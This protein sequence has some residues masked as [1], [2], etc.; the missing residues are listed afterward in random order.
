MNQQAAIAIA[1]RP[2]NRI[3]TGLPDNE[4][5]RLAPYLE[6][7]RLETR[8]LVIDINQPIS[9]V[10]FLNTGV[11][12]LVGLMA[13][14]SPVETATIG[15][16]GM[17]GLPVFH[18]TDRIAAQAFCQ[19]PAEGLR[20]SVAAFSA[21]VD[22]APVLTTLLHRYS[23]A[24]FTQVAQA[25]ACNRIHPVRQRCARW[26]LQTHDRVGA[27]EFSLTHDFLSQMLGV[28]RATVSETAAALQRD[29]LIEYRYG[30]IGI[31]SREGLELSSCE[32]YR[33]ITSEY[34]R[35]LDGKVGPSPLDGIV[36]SDGRK[37]I[38]GS[39]EPHLDDL[40]LARIASSD[41]R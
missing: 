38:L 8:D 7:V 3:L 34:D 26:L 21:E 14:R 2:R 39:P 25:S 27:D 13:D 29:G 5:A 32:C 31:T 40:E 6:D 11:V 41:R 24:V 4:Y 18:R 20:M 35:L 12:S 22:R 16:E 17:V 1:E 15:F 19:V 30:R 36:V 9:H 23:Q 37:S 10:Y 28:R 33:I